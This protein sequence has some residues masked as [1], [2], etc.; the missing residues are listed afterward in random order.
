MDGKVRFVSTDALSAIIGTDHRT[1]DSVWLGVRQALAALADPVVLAAVFKAADTR[2]PASSPPKARYMMADLDRWV[3]KYGT[4]FVFASRFPI[5]AMK[6]HRM[7]CAAELAHG[8]AAAAKLGRRLFDATWVEDR[9]LN[10]VAELIRFGDDVG[11]GGAA[12]VAATETQGVKDRLRVNTDEAIARGMFGAPAFYT[13]GSLFWGN[14]RLEF[15][16]RA[17][18]R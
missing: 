5:N 2:M 13:D 15:L 7:I 11:L 18:E 8:P 12:L 16:E 9:D 4:P 3:A 17:L 1:R 14:D 6:A 10:D